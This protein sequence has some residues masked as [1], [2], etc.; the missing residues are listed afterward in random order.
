M[1]LWQ[2]ESGSLAASSARAT[3][4]VGTIVVLGASVSRG[5]A[6]RP[7]VLECLDQS[8]YDLR[9][10]IADQERSSTMP[11]M[12]VSM[13]SLLG[14]APTSPVRVEVQPEPPQRKPQGELLEVTHEPIL[15]K[16]DQP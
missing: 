14:G 13:P 8:I 2:N 1:T 5:R 15:S 9:S 10:R 3:S 12:N 16:K 6:Q 4:Q 11:T 7:H